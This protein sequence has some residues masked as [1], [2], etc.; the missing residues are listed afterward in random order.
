M[1]KNN[2]ILRAGLRVLYIEDEKSQRELLTSKLTERG[3]AIFP[4]NSGQAGLK[5]MEMNSA[6]IVLCDLNMPEMSGL[7]LFQTLRQRGI[8]LPFMLIT[9]HGSIEMAWQAIQQGVYHFLMKPFDIDNI[10]M[11]MYQA[12]ELAGLI[13]K[14]DENAH[15]LEAATIDLAKANVNL[16]GAREALEK[17][18]KESETLLEELA[19]NREELQAILDSSPSAIV[20]ANRYGKVGSANARVSDFFGVDKKEII[21]IQFQKFSQKIE[22]C[23]DNK[24]V[25]AKQLQS[26]WTHPDAQKQEL[27]LG[28]HSYAAALKIATPKERF[29]NMSTLPVKSQAGEEL[30]RVWIYED[31]T[32]PKR[33]DEQLH[34]L[35][36]SSPVPLIISRAADGRI[37]YV[38]DVLAGLVGYTA[39]EMLGMP[40]LD[41]YADSA[42]R[43]VLIAKLLEHKFIPGQELKIRRRDGGTFWTITS[44]SL[45]ELNGETVVV[46]GFYDISD[47]KEAE[48]ALRVSEEKFRGF[49]ENAND[50]VFSMDSKGFLKYLSPRFTYLLGWEAKEFVGK[51]LSDLMHP[52]DLELVNEWIA[53]GFGETGWQEK[54]GFR[55]KHKNGEWRWFTSD[56]TVIRNDNG[57]PIEVMGIAHDITEIR[58]LVTG[59][60]RMNKELKDTQAQLAQAE[61]MASLGLLVAGIAHEINTPVGAISSMND[62]LQRG[63]NKLKDEVAGATFNEAEKKRFGNLFKIVEEATQVINSGAARVSTIVKRLRSFARLDEAE[64]KT[65]NIHEGLEDTLTLVHHE[66][67]HDIEVVKDY[68]KI[69]SISCFP[70]Q[71]NQ[72]FLNL[73]INARQAIKGK[74]KITIATHS[75]NNKI[76]IKISDTGAGIAKENLGRVFDPG[77]TT[78]GVGVGTG[79]GLSICYQIIKSH[80]GEISVTSELGHGTTFTIM[81]PTNLDKQIDNG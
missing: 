58:N 62:S 53:S 9:A 17:K 55:L 48:Q 10:E 29:V 51:P 43:S 31:V 36:E 72:V 33:A 80:R 59:L 22:A 67:K 16:L 68:G 64:L 56:A 57:T 15:K 79:L 11:L 32:V 42:E 61:K 2:N 13:Q 34:T 74:G 26:L 60:E 37:I 14:L 76:F 75:Q 8:R 4:M 70:G 7:E 39:K 23:F 47:R 38:N 41:F 6:D 35:I 30:G 27:S 44:L 3:H 50:V 81:L 1:P 45:T 25:Y 5:F 63:L 46:G 54:Y 18:Q 66:L 24:E 52:Q 65:V 21:G 77:F 28:Q 40:T 49:V 78:K 71:L 69:D 73:I 20:M 19:K 12:V